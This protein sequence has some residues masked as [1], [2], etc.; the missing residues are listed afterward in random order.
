V[1]EGAWGSAKEKHCCL[2]DEIGERTADGAVLA[3][4]GSPGLP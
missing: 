1:E 2:G 3:G 4:R